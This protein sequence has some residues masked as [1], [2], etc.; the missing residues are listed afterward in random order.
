[1]DIILWY[2]FCGLLVTLVEQSDQWLYMKTF[3]SVWNNLL[4]LI[5]WPIVITI[6]IIGLIVLATTGGKNVKDR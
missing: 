3:N 5:L 2:L 4:T 6:I 1:M